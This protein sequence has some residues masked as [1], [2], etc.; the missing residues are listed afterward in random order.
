MLIGIITIKRGAF[1]GRKFKLVNDGEDSTACDHCA[2]E[3]ECT[4]NHGFCPLREIGIT[5]APDPAENY[6]HFED[7][8][9]A[10]D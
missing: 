1:A 9:H 2:I 6:F 8:D 10:T 7:A 3:P 4:F 5:C